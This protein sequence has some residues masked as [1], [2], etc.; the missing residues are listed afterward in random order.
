MKDHSKNFRELLE[1]NSVKT[2]INGI[3]TKTNKDLTTTL[4]ISNEDIKKL[5]KIINKS[6]NHK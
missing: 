1:T 6:K 4:N 3:R 2:R 5:R